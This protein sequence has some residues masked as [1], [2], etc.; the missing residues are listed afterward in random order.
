[1][2][3][4]GLVADAGGNE[5]KLKVRLIGELELRDEGRLLP[6]PASKKTRALFVYLL[7]MRRPVRR[8]RLCELFFDIS[9]DPRAALRWSLS[10]IRSMLGGFSNAL[11]AD[12]ER[13]E[14][15][16]ERI[17]TDVDQV[18]FWLGGAALPGDRIAYAEAVLEPPLPGLDVSGLDGW[19][20][21]LAAE[22]AEIDQIR[23]RFLSRIAQDQSLTPEHRRLFSREAESLSVTR[24]R[25]SSVA[26]QAA[27][28]ATNS[29]PPI[30]QH[31]HY[32]FAPDGVR[33]AYACTGSGP[34]LVKAANWL[35]HLDLD[36]TGPVWG[37][38]FTELS[39]SHRLVR[40]DERGNGLS[41]WDVD[42]ISL[43]A[44]VRDLETV[45]D[46]L[47]LERFP[48]LGISQGCAVSIEYAARHPSRV[49]HLIL[50]GGYAAGWRH[51]AG[52]AEAEQREA[53][54]TLAQH[55]WG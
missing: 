38:M 30:E 11:V 29:A 45:V 36:W 15:R 54:I 32:C 12:R 2:A 50:L 40:Y 51:T 23:A 9:D 14:L 35:N 3:W 49:S 4:E 17:A 5:G 21:W 42:D 18:R 41:D 52:A 13:V 43:D 27:V 22:R 48:L 37:R 20:A 8:E 28:S 39:R 44:F 34:P 24:S 55:G 33:I 25:T 53:V 47:G 26:D 7:Q 1:M 46:S 10:K 16:S 19:N 31:V 6:L